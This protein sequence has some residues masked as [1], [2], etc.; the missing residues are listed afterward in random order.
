[1][2]ERW[3]TLPIVVVD[4]EGARQSTP[5]STVLP[6]SV[7]R[8]V[9]LEPHAIRRAVL[10]RLTSPPHS[11]LRA[12]LRC[13]AETLRTELTYSFAALRALTATSAT[14][15]EPLTGTLLGTI[16]REQTHV[17]SVDLDELQRFR[18]RPGAVEMSPHFVPA[19]CRQ[20]AQPDR[21]TIERGLL[22]E[23]TTASPPMQST[24]PLTLVPTV[25]SFL[26]AHLRRRAATA[27]VSVRVTQGGV[28]IGY[29]PRRAGPLGV[30]SWPLLLAALVLQPWSWRVVGTT[31]AEEESIGLYP[32]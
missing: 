30:R 14:A 19:L 16:I 23:C 3:P 20:L 9:P 26:R 32:V 27:V 22:C 2:T 11:A 13:I 5:P 25:T 1:L 17:L 4:T 31:S 8:T 21:E 24:G 6:D 10:E 12:T 15:M 29:Q 7:V 28:M 18:D